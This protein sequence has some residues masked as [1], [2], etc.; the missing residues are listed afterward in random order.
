MSRNENLQKPEYIRCFNCGTVDVP[1]DVPIDGQ[2]CTVCRSDDTWEALEF[3]EVT[4]ACH[5]MTIAAERRFDR[6]RE[7]VREN[8]SY[9]SLIR[10]PYYI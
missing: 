8:D 5:D 4:A 9:I 7:A 6:D 3:E 2:R 10:S 1:F